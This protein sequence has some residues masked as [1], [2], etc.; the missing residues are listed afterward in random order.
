[1]DSSLVVSLLQEL[2]E[3]PVRTF[4]VSFEGAEHDEGPMAAD[5]ARRLGSHRHEELTVTGDEAL[6]VVASLP[7]WF[8]EPLA[9]PSQIPTYLISRLARERVTVALSGDGGDELFA[10]YHRY[11][12]GSAWI[13]RAL[14]AGPLRGTMAHGLELLGS[15]PIS[16]TIGRI[17]ARAPGSLPVRLPREKIAK[18]AELFRA[19]SEVE[20]YRSLLSTR[21]NRALKVGPDPVVRGRGEMGVLPWMMLTDQL[22][23]LPGDLLAKVDRTSMAAS[24]EARVPLLD[25]RVVEFS[26]RLLDSY[27]IRDGRTKWPLRSILYSRLPRDIV[28]RPKV[29]FTVPLTQWLRGPLRPWAEGLLFDSMGVLGD[30]LDRKVVEEEWRSLVGGRV[31]SA[32]AVWAAVVLRQWEEHWCV[33]LRG[34]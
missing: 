4:S 30:V 28:D 27:K 19:G 32:S 16:K 9:N 1:V 29:G 2:R 23:Y 22:S 8:D 7:K 15:A 11:R 34:D 17:A 14:R 25:H 21:W 24:L 20:M 12:E 31:Q 13:R 10:G 33:G 3:E 6:G 26:W 18:L 5:V